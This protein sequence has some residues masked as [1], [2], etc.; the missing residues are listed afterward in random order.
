MSKFGSKEDL[1]KAIELQFTNIKQGS[2]T[3][4]ELELLVEQ[5]RELYERSL[6]LRYK[7]YEIQVF[8]EANT[9]LDQKNDNDEPILTSIINQV[10]DASLV[11]DLTNELL[12]EPISPTSP[13]DLFDAKDD[14]LNSPFESETH[15]DEPKEAIF[16]FDVFNQIPEEK[17]VEEEIEEEKII[18]QNQENLIKE[19]IEE[20]INQQSQQE[21]EKLEEESNEIFDRKDLEKTADLSNNYQVLEEN[22]NSSENNEIHHDL[23]T[24]EFEIHEEN[25]KI[26]ER[27]EVEVN[28]KFSDHQTVY[29]S[30][31]TQEENNKVSI[32]KKILDSTDTSTHLFLSKL[33]TLIGAFGFNE[34][35]Q[36]IQELFNGSTEDFNQAI[37][38]L[39]GLS[40]FHDAEKQLEFYVH[41]NNW[42]LESDVVSEFVRKIERRYKK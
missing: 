42:D 20:E 24:S 32:F 29:E 38:V 25:N 7:A 36:C 14:D 35:Y 16:D 3:R 15:V 19:E 10:S 4:E 9:E 33:D 5:T 34:K 8:G 13:T 2:L 12:Q 17:F 11:S 6:I 21:F 26:N 28:D 40:N 31:S 30:S 27:E 23:R 22:L 1:L 39:D 37:D 41:L 18:E